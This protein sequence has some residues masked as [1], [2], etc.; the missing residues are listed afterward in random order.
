MSRHKSAIDI[1]WPSSLREIGRELPQYSEYYRPVE[2]LPQ[3]L[4]QL[5][6]KM[7]QSRS[8]EQQQR[9]TASDD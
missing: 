5:L 7:N 4:R 3:H 9:G 8:T 1:S 2:K 6:R